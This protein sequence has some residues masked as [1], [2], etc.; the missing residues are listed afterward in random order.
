M[1]ARGS[2]PRRDATV[3]LLVLLGDPVVE[4]AHAKLA[5]GPPPACRG[6][7][8]MWDL[9]VE[10]ETTAERRQRHREAIAVCRDCPLRRECA[11]MARAMPYAEGVWGG[12]V[13]RRRPSP[14]DDGVRLLR[15]KERAPGRDGEDGRGPAVEPGVLAN[16]RVPAPTPT[17]NTPEL[18]EG[19]GDC[20]L[21][22]KQCARAEV[23]PLEKTKR[24]PT[25]GDSVW[26]QDSGG[27]PRTEPPGEPGAPSP[28]LPQ[29]ETE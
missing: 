23:F 12:E 17:P 18:G 15:R 13:F 5:E 1:S 4:A 7:A 25:S 11:E 2:E 28:I 26:R 24:G 10:G 3:E 21:R 6:R 9:S 16:G 27:G 8:A 20:D 14:A 19:I 22:R 29:E